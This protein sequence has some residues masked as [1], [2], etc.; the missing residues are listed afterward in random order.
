MATSSA[1]IRS[2]R[3]DP[4]GSRERLGRHRWKAERTFIWL[5]RF[6]WLRIRYER[7]EETL[8]AFLFLRLRAHRPAAWAT[9]FERRPKAFVAPRR[10]NPFSVFNNQRKD[11]LSGCQ[12]PEPATL[13]GKFP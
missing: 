9:G 5:N 10:P 8:Q 13:F 12:H 3:S 1:S 7:R 4:S 2:L 6:R 11:Q